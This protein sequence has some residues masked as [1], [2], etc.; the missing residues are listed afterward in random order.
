M[1]GVAHGLL[2]QA[3]V[4]RGEKRI[5]D[6]RAEEDRNGSDEGVAQQPL[7]VAIGQHIHFTGRRS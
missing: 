2:G 4:D 7:P 5:R 1:R 6:E 3:Q